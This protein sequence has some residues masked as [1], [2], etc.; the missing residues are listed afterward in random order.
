MSRLKA[1]QKLIDEVYAQ[2]CSGM[3]TFLEFLN[4]A[5]LAVNEY[6]A[7]YLANRKYEWAQEENLVGLEL[8]INN[9]Q[10]RQ[11]MRATDKQLDFRV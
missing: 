8:A 2:Y 9:A 6:N 10:I 1:K 5:I 3:I 4:G 11:R 7:D